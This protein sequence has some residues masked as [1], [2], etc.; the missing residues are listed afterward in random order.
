MLVPWAG[1][2]PARVAPLVFETSAS[3]DSATKA[4]QRAKAGHLPA[5]TGAKL[6]QI[7]LFC[8]FQSS[9]FKIKPVPLVLGNECSHANIISLTRVLCFY[10]RVLLHFVKRPGNESDSFCRSS[11]QGLHSCRKILIQDKCFGVAA[12]NSQCRYRI[13]PLIQPV[14]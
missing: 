3:T 10:V 9:I 5:S 11:E 14:Q 4:L 8:N 12:Y 7:V 13:R 6:N 1:V 2:E